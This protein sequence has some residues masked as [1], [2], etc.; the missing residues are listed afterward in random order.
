MSV[1]GKITWSDLTPEQKI[2]FGNGCGPD[3]LP[4]PVAKLLFGWFFEASCRHH[5]FNYQ[6]GGD[7]KDRL[8]ADRGFFKAML[9]DVKRLHWSLQLPAAIEALGFYGLVRFFGRFHFEDGQ[10][11]SLDQILK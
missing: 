6:R 7:D 5:D 1:Q 9:R 10:Y 11:K 2:S 3:W 4:E 8:S